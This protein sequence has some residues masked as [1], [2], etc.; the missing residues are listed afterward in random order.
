[1]ITILDFIK[2]TLSGNPNVGLDI[3]DRNSRGK[4]RNGEIPS[5]YLIYQNGVDVGQELW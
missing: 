4:L 3:D 2:E 1:M 5:E